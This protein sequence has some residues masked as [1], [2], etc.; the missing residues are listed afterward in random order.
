MRVRKKSGS[1][2][3][4]GVTTLKWGADG[5]GP[6]RSGEEVRPRF[7]LNGKKYPYFVHDVMFKSRRKKLN[8]MFIT[9]DHEYEDIR[10]RTSP[11]TLI[12]KCSFIGGLNCHGC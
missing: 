4:K 2:A 12:C 9:K 1:V 8:N 6:D 11:T 10:V 5:S 3:K 7:S